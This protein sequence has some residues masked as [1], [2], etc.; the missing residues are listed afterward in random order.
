MS[1]LHRS[2]KALRGLGLAGLIGLAGCGKSAEPAKTE[3]AAEPAAPV[4]AIPGPAT[5]SPPETP[6]TPV[7]LTPPPAAATPR[8]DTPFAEATTTESYP[9][10]QPPPM[11]TAAGQP[12]AKLHAAVREVWPTIK[13]TDADEHPSGIVVTLDTEAGPVEITLFPDIAPNHVRNF[14][15]LAQVGYYNGLTFERI[16]RVD[17][18]A[19]NGTKRKVE[20]LTAGCP[21]GDGEPAH[22][23]LGYFLKREPQSLLHEEG[24]VGFVREDNPNSA[25]CRI[26]ICLTP[27]PIMDGHFTAFG[28]VTG[29]LDVLKGI[30]ARPVKHLTNY[31][32]NELPQVPVKLK[33]VTRK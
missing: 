31:P 10:A 27:A 1:A 21:A 12:T 22:G 6:Y 24:A 9:G 30:A 14:L 28:K 29:G 19:D 18:V 23:H 25:C 8:L 2:W 26:Y 32:D 13:L 3:N 17:D 16:I 5:T 15:A 20:V 11:T 7:P 33:S 4:A